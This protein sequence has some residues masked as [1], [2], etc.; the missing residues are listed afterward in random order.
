MALFAW[1]REAT[2]VSQPPARFEDPDAMFHARRVVRTI[3]SHAWLPPV[4]DASENFPDGGRA[5]WPPL[6]D[7]SLALMARLGGSTAEEPDKGLLTA[8]AFPVLELVGVVLAAA[9]LARRFGGAKGAAAAAWLAALSPVLARRGAF[10]EID[11]NVTEV[12]GALL[13]ALLAATIDARFRDG[14]RVFI[15]AALFA[16]GILLSLGFFAGLAL[17]AAFVAGG[18]LVRE[19]AAPGEGEGASATLAGGFALSALLLP[20]FAGLRVKPDPGDPWRLGP[21]YV[22][23]LAAPALVCAV[24]AL[25]GGARR[26]F[27]A[28]RRGVFALASAAAAAALLL[29]VRAPSAARAGFAKGLGFIGSTDRWLSTID[30]FRPATSWDALSAI[31]PAV[32]VGLVAAALALRA[33]AWRTMPVLVPALAFLVLALLQKR[34]L[35][36]AAA[37]GA[38]AAGAA[39]QEVKGRVLL[40][41][42]VLGTLAAAPRDLAFAGITLRAENLAGGSGD[43][44]AAAIVRDRTDPPADPPAWGVLAPWDYGHT[45]LWQTGRAVALNPF[46]SFHPGFRRATSLFLETSPKKAL[47]ELR[48]LKL[49]YVSAAYPPNV[50]P[51]AAYALG[52][53]ARRFFTDGFAVDRLARYD[54]TEDGERTLA[55]RLHLHDGAPLPGDSDADKEALTHFK[56][57]VESPERAPGPHGSSVPFLKL[58][59]VLP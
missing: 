51:Q 58:F 10:G 57:I 41:A 11:H 50:V 37:F 7:A 3:A 1:H 31:L 26:G 48:A 32:L 13:L 38:A 15:G 12:L 22:L 53:D 35:P 44:I 46:G 27:A 52:L 47:D 23:V 17:S 36:L 39:F 18:Y 34:F 24:V 16:A 2:V 6:H 9:A 20:I 28:S 42:A 19:L 54:V 14:R 59:E 40:A 56:K 8:A 30:E 33:R 4:F 55:V 21:V 29:V 43:D 5:V 49:R 45:I 25:A